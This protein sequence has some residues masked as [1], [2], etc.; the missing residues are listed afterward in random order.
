MTILEKGRGLMILS[1]K[2]GQPGRH[3]RGTSHHTTVRQQEA[4]KI[5][6]DTKGRRKLHLLHLLL[7]PYRQDKKP[8]P[9]IRR[10]GV[11]HTRYIPGG[12]YLVALR[13][14][15]EPDCYYSSCISTS[16]LA[17]PSLQ[18]TSNSNLR[19]IIQMQVVSTRYAALAFQTRGGSRK[20]A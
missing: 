10:A 5:N 14:D 11:E 6:V 18:V 4:S 19:T 13:L 17:F 2:S 20:R 3:A 16:H 12:W 1:K 15:V 9:A 8:M 7:L